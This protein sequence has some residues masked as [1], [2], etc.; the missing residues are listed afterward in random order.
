MVSVKIRYEVVETNDTWVRYIGRAIDQDLPPFFWQKKGYVIGIDGTGWAYEET[1]DLDPG[2]HYV[3]V[4]TSSDAGYKYNI[5]VIIT[6]GSKVYSAESGLIIDRN[7]YC[8]Y[9]FKVE[10][11]TTP[12]TETANVTETSPSETAPEVHQKTTSN[13]YDLS[14]VFEE[15]KPVV[16]AM[17]QMMMMM[18]FMSAMMNMMVG[19]AGAT[20]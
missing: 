12:G 8:K 1:V 14:K 4:G 15:M 10:A 19:M 18:A 9:V 2:D 6:V 7:N 11:V 5:K 20:V 16:T 3:I 17:M 13:P